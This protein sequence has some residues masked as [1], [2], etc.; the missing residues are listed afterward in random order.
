MLVDIHTH[1]FPTSDNWIIYNV[2]MIQA[3]TVF[4]SDRKGLF[5]VGFHPWLIDVFSPDQFEKYKTWA[6]D[7]RFIAIG[8]CGFDK[9]S[10]VSYE[11]Q[12]DI[13]ERQIELSEEKG[14]PVI[15]HCVGYYN[16]LLS[17][18]KDWKPKQPWIVHGFRGKPQLAEQI[19]NH[20]CS[21]SFGEYFNPES[22]AIT[23]LE[24]LFLET[25]ESN[26]AIEEIYIR[27][28]EVKNCSI[29]ELNAGEKLLRSFLS[30]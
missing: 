15:I 1:K 13:F 11:K 16:E 3:E 4:S 29:R 21:L 14:K 30:Q 28:A 7:K 10:K 12:L 8:E 23:P 17:L 22:V 20:D 19:L 26:L 9:N 6:D 5:S 18:K 27:V 25:D 24:N 2:P